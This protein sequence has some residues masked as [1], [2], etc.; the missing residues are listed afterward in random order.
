LHVVAEAANPNGQVAK[1]IET[2]Q[3]LMAASQLVVPGDDHVT[4]PAKAARL[5]VPP[6][7]G[8]GDDGSNWLLGLGDL[9]G[10]FFMGGRVDGGLPGGDPDV[11]MED[12]GFLGPEDRAIER[13]RVRA[14]RSLGYRSEVSTAKKA[15]RNERSSFTSSPFV[16]GFIVGHAPDW[17]L[18]P[19]QLI[20]DFWNN[21]YNSSKPFDL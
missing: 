3:S 5:V 2:G 7:S 11:D 6:P 13:V 14:W 19:N 1:I 17:N 12:E 18:Q 8:G 20:F 10:G 4:P 16:G 21:Y 9:F 15:K